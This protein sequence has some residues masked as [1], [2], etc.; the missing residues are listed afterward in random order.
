MACRILFHFHFWSGL[1]KSSLNFHIVLRSM[2]NLIG[3][4]VCQNSFIICVFILITGRRDNCNIIYYCRVKDLTWGPKY[5]WAL[6]SS[7]HL[8]SQSEFVQI[9]TCNQLDAYLLPI[10]PS[11]FAD[12]EEM[13]LS[14]WSSLHPALRGVWTPNLLLSFSPSLPIPPCLSVANMRSCI[15]THFLSIQPASLGSRTQEVRKGK[16]GWR[17]RPASARLK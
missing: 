9:Q 15:E 16:L 6:L 8:H 2:C 7:A 17:Q 12:S 4:A 3:T 10:K 5:H 13:V 11:V 1:G 14:V